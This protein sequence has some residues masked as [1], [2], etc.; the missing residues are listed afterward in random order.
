MDN[1][2]YIFLLSEILNCYSYDILKYIPIK[3]ISLVSSVNKDFREA[4]ECFKLFNKVLNDIP[5]K[6]NEAKS[7]LQIK[8]ENK[9]EKIEVDYYDKYNFF[10]IDTIYGKINLG[11]SISSVSTTSISESMNKTVKKINP[12]KEKVKEMKKLFNQMKNKT[13]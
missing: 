13:Y 5:E 10:K 1:E 12:K 8:R 11:Q 9:E 7:T 4:V 3:E 2:R 6:L